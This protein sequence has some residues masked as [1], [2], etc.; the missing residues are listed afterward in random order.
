MASARQ[1]LC[2]PRRCIPTF[3]VENPLSVFGERGVTTILRICLA[4][5]VPRV[6]LQRGPQV[7]PNTD[8]VQALATL[9]K[10]P[11]D[12]PPPRTPLAGLSLFSG[13]FCSLDFLSVDGQVNSAPQGPC[14]TRQKAGFTCRNR[15]TPGRN[16]LGVRG[17]ACTEEHSPPGRCGQ[18][19]AHP[20]RPPSPDAQLVQPRAQGSEAK[21]SGRVGAGAALAARSPPA[22]A[23]PGWREGEGSVDGGHLVPHSPLADMVQAA[24]A[25]AGRAAETAG[26]AWGGKFLPDARGAPAA[27]REGRRLA[28]RGRLPQ[29]T[30]APRGRR[31]GTR[32]ARG[33]AGRGSADSPRPSWAGPASPPPRPARPARSSGRG[34]AP[35]APL[36]RQPELLSPSERGAAACG[37]GYGSPPR[38]EPL[39]K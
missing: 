26:R 13:Y 33:P 7:T 10:R 19:R 15:F 16:S 21:V 31:A 36:R 11:Q 2:R 38:P 27:A 4:C 20:P 14:D 18:R 3:G 5:F 1:G 22:P 32:R 29:D 39:G 6:K 9:S 34:D 12:Y 23:G 8:T 37:G 28:A 24:G 35:P 25:G 17:D 30:W